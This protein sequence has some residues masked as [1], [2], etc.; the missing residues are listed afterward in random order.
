MVR[1]D[2]FAVFTLLCSIAAVDA[3]GSK[4]TTPLNVLVSFN[5]LQFT[6]SGVT[7]TMVG[8]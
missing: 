4:N 7:H 2:S 5:V 6:S 1:T 3:K 8:S